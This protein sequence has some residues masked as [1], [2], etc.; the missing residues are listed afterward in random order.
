VRALF[1]TAVI[2]GVLAP[3]LLVAILIVASDERLMEGQP[4]PLLA[5]WVVGI[6]AF[7]MFVAV[8]AM[9]LL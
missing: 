5:R 2:N 6:T 4:S 9:F 7:I 1:L 8:I 3:F